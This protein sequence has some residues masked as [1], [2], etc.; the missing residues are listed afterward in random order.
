VKSASGDLDHHPARWLRI[1]A[2]FVTIEIVARP[3]SQRRGLIRVEGRGLVIGLASV[4]EKG[5]ANYELIA[6]IAE[7]T[8]VTRSAVSILCG[9][10]TREK[11]LRIATPKPAMMVRHVLSLSETE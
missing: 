5:K 11:V 2:D 10:S 6:T 7:L 9:A 3:G 8:G 4:A 1:G